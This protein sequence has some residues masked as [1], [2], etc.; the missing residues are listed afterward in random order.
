MAESA[1][2]A[3]MNSTTTE[4]RGGLLSYLARLGLGDAD[5][6]RVVSL[7]QAARTGLPTGLDED[8]R[9]TAP[10]AGPESYPD[11]TPSLE[12]PTARDTIT[13][14][15]AEEQ[16]ILK[17]A[18]HSFFSGHPT[19]EVL[20]SSTDTSSGSLIAAVTTLKPQ[21]LLLGVK[22]VQPETVEKLELLREACPQMGLVLLFAFYDVQGIKAL[23]GFSQGASA[24]CAYLLKHTIDTVEQLTQV[25]SSAAQG[26]VMMDPLVMEEMIRTEETTN[27]FLSELSSRE[28]E[29]LGWMAKGY[30]ND[31]IAQ[32]LSRDVKTVERH[33]NNIYSKMQHDKTQ[34]PDDSLHPRVRAT[35]IYLRA[36]GL[37]PPDQFIQES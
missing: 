1:W 20:D 15:L 27:S 10:P 21:V 6:T 24:G 8:S 11:T 37:L 26:R 35:L 12:A 19:I 23:R 14:Y 13:L 3:M 5:L 30:R 9:P 16:Q 33:I 32:A 2:G 29:V 22:T 25:V 28:L 31:T 17:E 4:E 7:L 34:G 36:S 18:Y